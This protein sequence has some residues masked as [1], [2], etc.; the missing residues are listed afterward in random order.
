MNTPIIKKW[1]AAVLCLLALGSTA[2]LAA[3]DTFYL[4]DGHNGPLTVSSSTTVNTYAQVTANV[5]ANATSIPVGTPVGAATSIPAGS[6]IMV[7]QTTGISPT[8]T[9]GDTTP[10][11][12]DG[13]PV[14]T[15]ELARVASVS[16]STLTLSA[17][18]VRGYTALVTQVIVVPEYTT[19][20]V[21]TGASIVSHP[22][23]GNVG[24][25]VAFLVQGT[26]SHEG[27]IR[28]NEQGF[29]GGAFL[30]DTSGT[31]AC[32]ELERVGPSGARKG[33]G[34]ANT[35][36]GAGNTGR[37]NVANGGGG[38]VCVRSG[39]G[40][41]GGAGA[42]GLGGNS[43]D[44]SRPYGGLGGAALS[45]TS[46]TRLTFG[47][48]GGAG[49]GQT[50]AGQPAGNGGGIV[51]VR[52][53]QLDGT[54]VFDASGATP[55]QAAE[56]GGGG[57][58]GGTLY[59]RVARAASCGSLN[60]FGGAGGRTTQT[61]PGPGGGGGG[62]YVLFQSAG[63]NCYPDAD[64]VVGANPGSRRTGTT[65]DAKPGGNGRFEVLP[66][67]YVPV[68]PVIQTPAPG[69]AL[70]TSPT[71]ISGTAEA[72]S[73]L[74]LVLTTGTTS[75]TYTVP[76]DASGNWSLN[77]PTLPTLPDGS[78]S[79]TVTTTNTAGD[80]SPPA[81]STFTV[82]TTAPAAPVIVTPP[83]GAVLNT[84]PT[85]ISGTAEANTTLSLVLTTGTTSTTYTVPVDA[86]GNWS[87]NSPTLPTLP[88]G[89]YTVTATTRDAAGN[90]SPPSLPS[91]FTVDTVA[92]AAPV[93]VTPPNGA[94][95][96]A[97]PTAISGTAEANTTL[98]LVL[99]TGTTST[100]YT[101]PVDAS[102]NWSLNSPTLPTLPD[103]SYTVTATTR[104]AAGNTSPPSLPST[105]TVD[106]VA[107]A[108]PV[109]VTP[110][111]GAVLSASPAAISGTAEANTTLSLVLTTGTTSTT[112]TVPVDASGNWSLTGPTLPTLGNGSYTATATTRDAAGNTSPPST[113][114]TF[115][116]DNTIPGA[117]VIVT[118]PNGALLNTSSVTIT[119]TAE[120][121][122]NLTLVINGTSYGPI[123]V[124][125]AGHWTFTP[126]T[127]ADG[128]Y[129]IEATTTNTAG[130]TSPTAT[131]T[132]TVD[133]TAPDAPVVTGPAN[134]STVTDTTP[135]VTGTAEPNTTVTVVIDGVVVGT[136]PVDGSGH[137]SYTPTTPLTPGPH[138]VVARAE[139]KAG[140]TSPDSS[141]NTFTVVPDTSA[142]KTN[143]ISGPSNTTPNRSATF[144]FDAGEPGV[145]YE[146]R[147]DGGEW[148]T[149]TS[150]VTYDNLP[151]GQHT[152]EVR[153]R[154]SEGN[155][156]S[157]PA[158]YTWTV[159][160]GDVDFRGDGLGCSAS[161]G[162]SSLVLMALGSVLALARR[163]QR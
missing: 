108:A 138:S 40:G 86:S 97:S 23:D 60:A 36:Y 62:G 155:V 44:G 27:E 133:T 127:L 38:G 43:A 129:S 139:D 15:W 95:L 141:S 148:T 106:T 49:H 149:C 3:P 113:P 137:W 84:S 163:R 105:F 107:P 1:L 92:P 78:Y 5:A 134:G 11:N 88:D 122:S 61:Q 120:A 89:S 66:G 12:L 79:V 46:L 63:G 57:G 117:P 59:L 24:G 158:S 70:N 103:G 112:Y 14:G 154:D 152:F 30:V 126:P 135:V 4:G 76:V 123:P 73:T 145:T 130:T 115:K 20:T 37:G 68:V 82:D 98:S 39:G 47:G 7:H 121:G 58:G 69:A 34:I 31:T 136:A 16:G 142:P 13:T 85:A 146:C 151:D 96:G 91:T 114:S 9:S 22:W 51:F 100:T 109:I 25:V 26:L 33:E 94:P 93:I 124:D 56:A 54:G 143:I 118:P 64:S 65:T 150:P 77:A 18:L 147:L 156:E 21:S 153:A 102:G 116:I 159:H 50:T 42:G 6:L 45:S 144:E 52:A 74:T 32:T 83:N 132:F 162:D 29:R 67:G 104:D 140:N 87:L 131:S 90:T 125:A 110:R 8:P 2:T 35:R 75:T 10:I 55:E 80:T 101:V 19:V 128:P 111:N 157:T 119:G 160:V 41:G 99:T 17:P 72:N 71:A 48:G 81:T 161:G 53:G 28:A